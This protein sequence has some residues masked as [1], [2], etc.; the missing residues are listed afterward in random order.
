LTDVD[1][2]WL[3]NDGNIIQEQCVFDILEAASDYV[4]EYE[5]LDEN[6]KGIVQR[7]RE[8]AEDHVNKIIGNKR[9]RMDDFFC[10]RDHRPPNWCLVIY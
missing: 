4:L 9:K 1:E 3:D 7:L 5:R 8:L 2:E 10:F 6:G